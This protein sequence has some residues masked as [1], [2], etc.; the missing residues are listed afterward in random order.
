MM[1][2]TRPSRRVQRHSPKKAA[3]SPQNSQNNES[4]LITVNAP[5]RP[6]K[7][8]LVKFWRGIFKF[9]FEIKENLCNQSNKESDFSLIAKEERK[10]ENARARAHQRKYYY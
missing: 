2:K 10:K 7:M 8:T 4:T 3:I 6:H 5:L 1:K 9:I